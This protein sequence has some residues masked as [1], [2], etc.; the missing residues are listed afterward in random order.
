M[1]YT[2]GEAAKILGIPASTLRYYDKEGLLPE[3][4]RSSGGMRMFRDSDFASLRL[5]QCLKKAGLPL[6][7]IRDFIRLPNDGQKTID[8]RLKILSHQKKLLRKKMEELEDMMGMVE[9]KIWYYETAKRAGTTKVPAGMKPSSL[10]ISAMPMCISMR[11][12]EKK[13]KISNPLSL[14]C[15][16]PEI[17][18]EYKQKRNKMLTE[19]QILFLFL[20][21]RPKNGPL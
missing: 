15:T 14:L 12:R 10:S 1:L 13:G 4:E 6:K 9:Y 18:Q 11:F 20:L 19:N 7:E 16:H 8:T 5:I 3:L 2:A 21:F 17:F